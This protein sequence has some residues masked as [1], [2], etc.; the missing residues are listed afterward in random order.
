MDNE[1]GVLGLPVKGSISHYGTKVEQL[2]TEQLLEAIKALLEDDKIGT[3][4]WVQQTPYFNDGDACEFGVKMVWVRPAVSDSDRRT[5]SVS[6][7]MLKPGDIIEATSDEDEYEFLT[8]SRR[9]EDIEELDEYYEDSDD[10][11]YEVRTY[12]Y[13]A[14]SKSPE[15]HLALAKMLE[16]GHY[17]IWLENTFGDPARVVFHKDH[18]EIEF[19][20]HD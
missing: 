8:V 15:H 13:G 6:P 12:A 20:D 11:K 16:S 17:D 2:P 14:E 18:I 1:D 5:L 4:G 3:F 9:I 7:N 10:Y 19:Y